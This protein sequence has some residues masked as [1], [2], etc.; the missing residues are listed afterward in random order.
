[1]FRRG[2]KAPTVSEKNLP[3][4]D[5]TSIDRNT[6]KCPFCQVPCYMEELLLNH[7]KFAHAY[8][9]ERLREA[10]HEEMDDAID[11]MFDI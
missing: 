7:I 1:M 2:K 5:G 10:V 8:D 6:F 11:K 3:A 9:E 4:K